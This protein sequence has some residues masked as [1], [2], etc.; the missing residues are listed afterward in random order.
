[1]SNKIHNYE[2]TTRVYVKAILYA[3]KHFIGELAKPCFMRF[4]TVPLTQAIKH[5]TKHSQ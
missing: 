4:M 5:L 3:H 1:M 2:G